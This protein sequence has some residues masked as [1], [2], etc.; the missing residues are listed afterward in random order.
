MMQRQA[1]RLQAIVCLL[2]KVSEQLLEQIENLASVTQVLLL[3]VEVERGK[4]T[5]EKL[6]Q[7]CNQ[8]PRSLETVTEDQRQQEH[9]GQDVE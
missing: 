7:G 4:E 6:D 5:Q 2:R 9:P 8:T 3:M 1:N